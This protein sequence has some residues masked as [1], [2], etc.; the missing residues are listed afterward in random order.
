MNAYIKNT[1]RSQ[2]NHLMQYLKPLGKQEQT[3][4]KTNRREIIKIKAYINKIETKI[5]IQCID[6][7]K[8]WFSEKINKIDKPF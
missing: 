4:P 8:S 1:E 3:K 7:T 2:I 5:I 6:E